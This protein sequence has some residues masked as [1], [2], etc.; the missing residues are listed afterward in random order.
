[1]ER[2]SE[3][4]PVLTKNEARQGKRGPGV[5]LVLAIGLAL[6]GIVAVAVWV[7]FASLPVAPQ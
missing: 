3:G 2:N 6:A 5:I 7:Y 1:M 4:A